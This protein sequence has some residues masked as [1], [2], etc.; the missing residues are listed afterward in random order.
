MIL[1]H[2][3]IPVTAVAATSLCFQDAV[4]ASELCFP[5]AVATSET[6]WCFSSCSS[7]TRDSDR[8]LFKS[9]LEEEICSCR[10]GSLPSPHHELLCDAGVQRS[11]PS[12]SH[13]QRTLRAQLLRNSRFHV[14]KFLGSFKKG[15]TL[16]IFGGTFRYAGT[17]NGCFNLTHGSRILNSRNQ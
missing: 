16:L 9:L 11:P 1:G 12:A 7:F 13:P 4:A 15:L 6:D 2:Q 3:P 10:L 14:L 17:R 5:D 8:R